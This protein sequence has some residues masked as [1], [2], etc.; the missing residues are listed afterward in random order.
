VWVIAETTELPTKFARIVVTD[1]RGRYVL[2]DLPN[3]TYQV[4]VRG[5]GLVD[6]RRVPARPGQP[7]NLSADVAP[8]AKTAA[9]V[10]PAAWWL[11]MVTP[12][13]DAAAQKDFA[14]GVK[15][16]H[17][18]HQLGNKSTREVPA[19]FMSGSSS[20]LEAWEKR[21]N[22]G[23]SSPYMSAFFH[24]LGEPRKAFADWT[25]RVAKGDTRITSDGTSRA[26]RARCPR[27]WSSRCARLRWPSDGLFE[28]ATCLQAARAV[29]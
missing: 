24:S 19:A 22:I 26:A 18:C 7:L 10:Y 2:P 20:S 14:L 23:P 21:V 16:C 8:D 15:E 29:T 17:D 27:W 1:D 12:P 13:Q 6:S 25:D 3:A 5:Y 9:E 11:S 28:H 4:F